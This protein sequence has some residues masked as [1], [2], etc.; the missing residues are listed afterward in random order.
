MGGGKKGGDSPEVFDFLMS[1][2]YGICYGPVDVFNQVWVKDKPIWC[3][4]ARDRID[5]EVSQDDLF[6]GDTGEGGVNG[7]VEVYPGKLDQRAS[8]QLGGRVDRTIDTM[9]GYAGLAHLF[10]R[11]NLGNAEPVR[12]TRNTLEL[13]SYT[14]FRKAQSRGFKW[15]TNNPYLGAMK[16]SV[17]R[18][19]NVI[20]ANSVIYPPIIDEEGNLADDPAGPIQTPEGLIDPPALSEVFTVFVLDSMPT[21]DQVR[22]PFKKLDYTNITDEEWLVGVSNGWEPSVVVEYKVGL[23]D[24]SGDDLQTRQ[25][26]R[27]YELDINDEIVETHDYEDLTGDGLDLDFK[28]LLNSQTRSIEFLSTVSPLE[29]TVATLAPGSVRDI[30]LRFTEKQDNADTRSCP[31]IEGSSGG[32]HQA[33]GEVF[34]LIGM[35]ISADAIDEGR[36]TVRTS[37]IVTAYQSPLGG[38]QP[39]SVSTISFYSGFGADEDGNIDWDNALAPYRASEGIGATSLSYPASSPVGEGRAYEVSGVLTLKPGTRFVSCYAVANIGFPVLSEVTYKAMSATVQGEGRIEVDSHCAVDGTL[40]TLPDANPAQMIYECLTNQN[41]GKSEDPSM[42]EIDTFTSAATTL[43][44]EFFGLSMIWVKQDEMEKFVQEILDHINAFLF[45]DPETGLWNLK[46]LRGDYDVSEAMHIDESNADL[47]GQKRRAWG[48]TINEVVVSYTDPV[49]EKSATVSSHNLG[50]IAMNGGIISETRDYY[51]VR[52]PIIAKIIADRDVEEAGY[53]VFTCQAEVDRT[54]WRLRP[55][56]VV[57]LS[58]ADEGLEYVVMRVMGVDYGSPTDRTILLDLTEDIFALEQTTY[59]GGQDSLLVDD[60]TEATPLDRQ[61]VVT[62]PLPSMVRSGITQVEADENEP[63]VVGIVMAG[64]DPQPMNI[65]VHTEVVKGNGDEVFESITSVSPVLYSETETELVKEVYSRLPEDLVSLLFMGQEEV[66]GIMMLGT[67]ESGSELV[68][69]DDYFEADEEWSVIRGVWDTVPA[70]WPVGSVV[71]AFPRGYSRVDPGERVAGETRTYRLL[72]KTSFDRL[73]FSDADDLVVTFSDRPFAPFR[74]ANC[75]LD[76]NGPFEGVDYSRITTDEDPP[77]TI[78]ASWVNR[79]RGTED[80]VATSWDSSEMTPEVGQTTVLRI[81]DRFG[82][83]SHEITG[84][85]GSSYAI[86]LASFSPVDTG[87]IEFV[88]DRDGLRSLWGDRLPFD[89]NQGGY[90]N[91]YGYGYGG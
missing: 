51:G 24:A 85:T 49:T 44:E 39:D 46:L 75:Q 90:G 18:L 12:K 41:W 20:D 21:R 61:M 17:T 53:P 3:G 77:A 26:V 48:E 66:G 13:I 47:S 36:A 19:P 68:M 40:G 70:L 15:G 4:S 63:V 5:I 22:R 30:S 16:A 10:F 2:D 6:G 82:A 27:I 14:V 7:T 38:D 42:I 56:D 84:L 9:P 73:A 74:P 35:G 64:S 34:D 83:F 71:W 60:Q 57:T 45:Q 29:G 1:I 8:A 31:V 32:S 89:F 76:G 54:F 88:S 87:T 28:M 37:T 81:Y 62:A 59:S 52:N 67:E 11:G 78:T 69:L 86:P 25:R 58:W 55:G 23:R 80:A 33:F 79:N 72:P 43:H 50:N 91:G 65:Q